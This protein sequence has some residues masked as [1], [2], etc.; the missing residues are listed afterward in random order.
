MRTDPA[1]QHGVAVEQQ[2]LRRERAGDGAAAGG[3]EL[4][5]GTGGDMLEHELESR[6]ARDDAQ[7]VALDER[8]L[9]VEDVD[10]G[11][12]HLAVQLQ[13]HAQLFHAFEH[14][15]GA[16]EV[17]HARVRVGGG[18]GRVVLHAADEAAGPGAV[19]LRRRGVVG[20]VERHQRLEA[21]AGGQGR[22]NA[23]A[24]SRCL[25]S[26]GHRRPQVG[27]H[28]G[29]AEAGGGEAQHGAHG[30]VIA[31]VQMP[32]VGSGD[33]QRAHCCSDAGSCSSS[34]SDSRKR[35]PKPV[36][37]VVTWPRPPLRV[38]A[39]RSTCSHGMPGRTKRDRNRAA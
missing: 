22:E 11:V 9:A 23:V 21:A 26:R 27:H 16:L 8:L 4:D 15:E 17:G 19:D 39:D 7:Q 38:A 24:V 13:H 10:R 35:T 33:G 3:H 14:A 36:T 2:V 25:S 30:V 5:A 37:S 18:A 1:R 29:A 20:E 28:H 12:R 34:S 32:V 6:E 31:Q